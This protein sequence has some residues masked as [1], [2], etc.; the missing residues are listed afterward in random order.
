[1][2]LLSVTMKIALLVCLFFVITWS[3]VPAAADVVPGMTKPVARERLA[4]ILRA[5]SACTYRSSATTAKQS[6]ITAAFDVEAL[7]VAPPPKISLAHLLMPLGAGSG[8]ATGPGDADSGTGAGMT[9]YVLSWLVPVCSSLSAI[10]IFSYLQLS[11]TLY[12]ILSRF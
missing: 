5:L 6:D 1:M 3:D 7:C 10:F 4:A 2:T 9:L 8:A 12:W 11:I